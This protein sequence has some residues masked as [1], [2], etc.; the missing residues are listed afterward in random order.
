MTLTVNTGLQYIDATLSFPNGLS[1]GDGLSYITSNYALASNRNALPVT[2][3]ATSNYV[4][5]SMIKT[6]VAKNANWRNFKIYYTNWGQNSVAEFAGNDTLTI[7]ACI[8]YN[9]QTYQSNQ[10][11]LAPNET[12]YVTLPFFVVNAYDGSANDIRVLTRYV[13]SNTGSIARLIT[14]QTTPAFGE[15][16]DGSTNTSDNFTD[17]SYARGALAGAV[18]IGGGNITA[19][20]VAA[21]GQN[22]NSAS[23]VYAWQYEAD[24]TLTYK[25]VGFIT[26]TGSAVSGITITSGTPPAGKTWQAAPNITIGDNFTILT[27]V[28]A[29]AAIVA[30]PDRAVKSIALF[31]D[32]ITRGYG[33]TDGIGDLYRNFG[34]LERGISNRVGVINLATAGGKASYYQNSILYTKTFAFFA[35]LRPSHASIALGSND[36]VFDS[37]TQS[38][39][40]TYLST[41]RNRIIS[42]YS[43]CLVNNSTLIPRMAQKSIT[44]I[45]NANPAVITCTSHNYQNGDIVY[46]NSASGMTQI[47]NLSFTVAN[48]TADTFEL[49]GID[50]TLYG[51][52]TGNGL[53]GC[54]SDMS[55]NAASNGF[56]AGGTAEL[57]NTDIRNNTIVSDWGYID[58]HLALAN[59]SDSTQWRGSEG[60][61]T[62]DLTHPSAIGFGYLS[63]DSIIASFFYPISRQ[64][65]ASLDTATSGLQ[66]AVGLRRMVSSYN[67]KIFRIIRASDSLQKDFYPFNDGI[68]LTELSNFL[69]GTTGKIVTL[70][71]QS[72]IG[73][74]ATQGTDA[75]RPTVTL[76]AKNSQPASTYNGSSQW[77]GCDAIAALIAPTSTP[78]LTLMTLGSRTTVATS[79]DSFAFAA[80]AVANSLICINGGS[81]SNERF[82]LRDNAG[83]LLQPFKSS[84][85]TSYHTLF[86]GCSFSGTTATV[87]LSRDADA[88]NSSSGTQGTMTINNANI[89]S[90]YS[91]GTRSAYWSGNI[92]SA[93]AWNV[94]LTPTQM[95]AIYTNQDNFYNLP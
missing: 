83:A 19:I 80:N 10:I 42:A 71:D 30:T 91:N 51:V 8:E 28:Y 39:L 65:D 33:A 47:N 15:G 64:Y 66:F 84:A 41:I 18:T 77:L 74:N 93:A 67:S 57:I 12:G 31:G 70:Y 79:M 7:Q 22:Y 81:T 24:G 13:G 11:V 87:T 49:S 62:E 48:R 95:T 1:M 89:G 52:Y 88:V 61:L 44:A 6:Y 35:I 78:T 32:S 27:S 55:R 56:T 26:R 60:Y 20:A 94:T 85:D 4:R 68:I 2:T 14:T 3:S 54:I 45:T 63:R 59:P 76:A 86:G 40:R 36:I 58:S 69:S 29:P 53:V 73:N 92:L 38:S 21:G 34:T 72:G 75:N 90:R 43:S 16:V 5:H 9:G 82:L 17:G 50:S 46:I 25:S 23:S 37:V